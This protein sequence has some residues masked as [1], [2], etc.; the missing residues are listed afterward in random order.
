MEEETPRK[1]GRP[2]KIK[3]G[4]IEKDFSIDSKCDWCNIL[5]KR[6]PIYCSEECQDA[7]E[8]RH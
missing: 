4:E 1:R 5:L 6:D 2:R 8:A 7:Y 3:E